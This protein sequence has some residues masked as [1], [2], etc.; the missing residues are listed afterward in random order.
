MQTT[1]RLEM[2]PAL[3]A[4]SRLG[5]FVL[6]LGDGLDAAAAHCGKVKRRKDATGFTSTGALKIEK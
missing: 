2:S 5:G 4:V 6:A 1:G 3:C